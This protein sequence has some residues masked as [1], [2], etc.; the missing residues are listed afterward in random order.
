VVRRASTAPPTNADRIRL[1]LSAVDDYEDLE[2][3]MPLPRS[4]TMESRPRD[5]ADYW[6]HVLHMALLRKFF[7][8]DDQLALWRVFDSINACIPSPRDEVV[9]HLTE[10]RTTCL[11]RR[12]V[13]AYSVNDGP[14]RDDNEV[15]IDELYGRHLHVDYDRWVRAQE[16]GAPF[17]ESAA[18]FWNASAQRRLRAV[19]Q[20]IDLGVGDG[21]MVL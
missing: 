4:F 18:L 1:F 10:L 20:T 21:T 8:G 19:R 14:V 2:V 17:G 15:A 12:S 7:Y 3:T 9:E 11:E 16:G 5:R 13:T 6:V